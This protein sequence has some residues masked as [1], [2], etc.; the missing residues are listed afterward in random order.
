MLYIVNDAFGSAS[1]TYYGYSQDGDSL[2]PPGS[3]VTV[4]TGIAN[5]PRE[6]IPFPPRPYVEKAFD[7]VPL[8]RHAARRPF[9]RHGGAGP[10][11]GRYP[12]L[13]RNA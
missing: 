4:P 6:I 11:A 9:R 10:A 5:F 2:L 1:W 7:V 8:D 12:H 3:R 13:C